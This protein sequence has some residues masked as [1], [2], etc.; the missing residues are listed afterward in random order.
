[1]AT[2][3]YSM[4]FPFDAG[5]SVLQP[6]PGADRPE[7]RR[8]VLPSGAGVRLGDG[9]PAA[10]RAV[11]A[12]PS[13]RLC[14]GAGRRRDRLAA[15]LGAIRLS[16]LRPRAIDR[17]PLSI[18]GRLA[19]PA[20]PSKSNSGKRRYV[21]VLETIPVH[22]RGDIP[23]VGA[24]IATAAAQAPYPNR[25][26]TLVLP[27]AA[28]SGTDTTTRIISQELGTALGVGIVI[29][30]KAGANGSIAASYVARAA[31]GR[32]HAVRD[33]QHH[34]FGQSVSA[35]DHELRSGQGFHADRANRRPALHAGDPSRHS[36]QF[37]RRTDRAGKE[38]SGQ[39]LLR[40]RQLLGDRL[41]R[42]LRPPRRHRPAACSL[43]ELAAGPDRRDRRPRLD[44][45]RRRP[46]PAC[47]TSTARR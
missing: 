42:D 20:N 7:P 5:L 32:L 34:A 41:G 17:L 47:R 38:G 3:G 16:G 4:I 10:R 45:V 12:V 43:Q 18:P 21:R 37:G 25:N 29:E 2:L 26:I 14:A 31:A 35:Q 19:C 27:F 15:G 22:R 30:N 9:D 36:R 33:H 6:R 11:A 28:G 40:Q 23:A 46:R 13:G 1:M 39:I 44:D 8:A 24:G